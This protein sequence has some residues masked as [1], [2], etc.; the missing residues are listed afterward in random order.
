MVFSKNFVAENDQQKKLH[1]TVQP[2]SIQETYSRKKENLRI[3]PNIV[4]FQSFF[5]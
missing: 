2:Q 3:Q 5:G 1:K 4:A